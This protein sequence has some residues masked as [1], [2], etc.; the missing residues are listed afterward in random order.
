MKPGLRVAL[1]DILYLISI[2]I[3]V[4]SLALFVTPYVVARVEDGWGSIVIEPSSAVL[5]VA[6]FAVSIPFFIAA[7]LMNINKTRARTYG[8]LCIFPILILTV[9]PVRF[10]E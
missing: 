9:F 5:V 8:I 10:G 7:L 2:V 1:A 6:M 3:E 4:L